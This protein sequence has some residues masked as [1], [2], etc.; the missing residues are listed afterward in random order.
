MSVLS[1]RESAAQHEAEV[2]RERSSPRKVGEWRLFQT[3]GSGTYAKVKYAVHVDSNKPAAIKIFNIVDLAG[4]YMHNNNSKKRDAIRHVQDMLLEEMKVLRMLQHPNVVA[5][6][7][8]YYGDTHIYLAME[9]VAGGELYYYVQQHGKL[10]EEK[11]CSFFRQLVSALIYCHEQGVVHRDIKLENLLLTE[12]H[13]QLKLSDFG[14]SRTFGQNELL[15][16]VCGSCQYAA[17]EMTAE[18]GYCA[19][20]ADV[21]SAGVVL[22]AMVYGAMPF[23]RHFE[24]TLAVMQS[25]RNRNYTLDDNSVSRSG[26]DLLK[27]LLEPEPAQRI[28]LQAVQQHSWMNTAGCRLA[29]VKSKNSSVRKLMRAA[30]R[31]SLLALSKLSLFPSPSSKSTEDLPCQNSTSSH[32]TRSLNEAP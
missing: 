12:D 25:A 10:T 18:T 30:R 2:W 29:T 6:Y 7:N 4:R 9:L 21:W 15:S 23:G 20:P 19:P 3:L 32:S 5:Y 17:P 26:N 27:Q 8:Y 28:T 1:G 11:A 31:R 24:D 16:T 13:K 22:Y 14:F